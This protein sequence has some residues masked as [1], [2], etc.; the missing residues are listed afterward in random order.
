MASLSDCL[1]VAEYDQDDIDEDGMASLVTHA[2]SSGNVQLCDWMHED[3]YPWD[4]D[5]AKAAAEA[6][7]EELAHHLLN[8]Y[9]EEEASAE[10][11]ANVLAGAAAGCSLAALRRMYERCS[12]EAREKGKKRLVGAAVCGASSEWQQKAE[13]LAA[14]LQSCPMPPP[15]AWGK[16]ASR[17]DALQ[18]LQWVADRNCPLPMP[19]SRAFAKLC[20]CVDGVTALAVVRLLLSE[21]PEGS[22]PPG[23][24]AAREAAMAG[25]VPV[26]QALVGGG[27]AMSAQVL[28]AA[29]CNGRMEAVAWLAEMLLEQQE[30]QQQQQQD[31]EG[32]ADE[33]DE[34][35]GESDE[36]DEEEGEADEDDEEEGEADEDDEE[37]GE[38]DEDDEEVADGDVVDEVELLE[39]LQ[40]LGA[41]GANNGGGGGPLQLNADLFVS[42]LIA[43]H[44]EAAVW[45]LD[46]GCPAP[47][48]AGPPLGPHDPWARVAEYGSVQLLEELARRGYPMPVSTVRC[49]RQPV[50]HLGSA[51]GR[52]GDRALGA[53]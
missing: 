9:G 40:G 29:L 45:L 25:H 22:L 18:R 31:E 10:C 21:A 5:A 37:E 47:P 26:L 7:H 6:G 48:A 44:E 52:G 17:P 33:D 32:E 27:C 35:E 50:V 13:W 36:D 3:G 51:P 49:M 20:G 14:E 12:R 16:L 8:I 41:G 15:S 11:L 24:K 28:H 43:G 34:E 1:Q 39:H 23:K 38:A 42:V 30:N 2:A 53:G 4:L 19:N 46:K